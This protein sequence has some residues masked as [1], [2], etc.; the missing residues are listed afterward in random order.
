MGGGL[1]AVNYTLPTSGTYSISVTL[2][3]TAIQGS[4]FS[5]DVGQ[6]AVD[7]T[8]SSASAVG[9][10]T[11]GVQQTFTITARDLTGSVLTNY[12]QHF[13]I[14]ASTRGQPPV[15]QLP[16]STTCAA[17]PTTS[18]AIPAG[19]GLRVVCDADTW[20]YLV[21]YVANVAGS[22]SISIRLL[23]TEISNSPY[24]TTLA[25]NNALMDVA[26]STF[27]GPGLTSAF[28][29]VQTDFTV[30]T[31]DPYGNP[32]T[33]DSPFE[34]VEVEPSVNT[35]QSITFSCSN[36]GQGG[37]LH[38]YTASTQATFSKTFTLYV[39]TGPTRPTSH[40]TPA[41][42]KSTTASP[43]S[44]LD[45]TAGEPASFTIQ[46]YDAY[47]NMRTTGGTDQFAMSVAGG[48]IFSSS[49]SYDTSGR[50][51][52]TYSTD[53]AGSYSVQVTLTY[54]ENGVERT[55][56][57]TGSAFSLTVKPGL[58]D[59]A[60]CLLLSN[61]AGIG[62]NVAASSSYTFSVVA[63]DRFQNNVPQAQ[64]AATF[65]YLFSGAGTEVSGAAASTASTSATYTA[66]YSLSISG[67]YTA[68]VTE[69][70]TT[71]KTWV[72]TVSA[73]STPDVPAT[74]VQG[75]GLQQARAGEVATFS[76]TLKDAAGNVITSGTNVVQA[77]LG[78][79][80]AAGAMV[81]TVGS[82]GV[83]VA[84]YTPTVVGSIPIFVDVESTAVNGAGVAFVTVLPGPISAAQSSLTASSLPLPG[85]TASTTFSFSIQARDAFGNNITLNSRSTL[86]PATDFNSASS[87]TDS[88]LGK[89]GRGHKYPSL[90]RPT[91]SISTLP[92]A[93]GC[94]KDY[95]EL[96]SSLQCSS[97]WPL[98]RTRSPLMPTL[99]LFP[100][101]LLILCQLLLQ[102]AW[103]D[104]RGSVCGGTRGGQQKPKYT[105]T[106][107][108]ATWYSPC[109]LV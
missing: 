75:L 61:G 79:K 45:A 56:P 89:Q 6:T 54:S 10:A 8:K 105:L 81:V 7:P 84:T 102:K 58:I 104:P 27:S 52:M 83:F 25:P 71:V 28:A 74:V 42:V 4:P 80:T 87:C 29:S 17:H 73:A 78:S 99:L 44:L 100:L 41:S 24:G 35:Y 62:P 40:L 51:I 94:G 39:Q 93:G 63:R 59:P 36:N 47:G 18:P 55:A 69:G 53:T 2:G 86:H 64:Q 97:T 85:A 68:T 31:S 76:I 60:S 37:I 50:Y 103:G 95:T 14:V 57:I 15:Q 92:P 26:L 98:D 11:A 34:S 19:G 16:H 66:T 21:T 91:A 38:R 13:L 65:R 46:A 1:Y 77:W 106:I 49:L 48:A 20:R 12:N 33:G 90:N 30:E 82:N 23:G 107:A 9:P 32:R 43:M 72:L 67:Q 22:Y 70:G 96:L 88:T 3:G 101:W 5:L 108:E 109:G